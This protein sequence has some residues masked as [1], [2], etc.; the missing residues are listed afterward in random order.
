MWKDGKAKSP[1]H[2]KTGKGLEKDLAKA[3]ADYDREVASDKLYDKGGKVVKTGKAAKFV[4]GIRAE[5][6]ETNSSIA[7]ELKNFVANLTA[8]DRKILR[9]LLEEKN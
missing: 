5:E 3:E 4:N 6:V 2:I 7:E 9:G 1:T 8:E